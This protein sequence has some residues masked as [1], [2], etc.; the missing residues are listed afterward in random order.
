MMADAALPRPY[1]LRLWY[2]LG[3]LLG[4][5]RVRL[6]AHSL[7]GGGENDLGRLPDIG[8]LVRFIEP[9][10]SA[11]PEQLPEP[12]SVAELAPG[13]DQFG[14][15]RFLAMLGEWEESGG[16]HESARREVAKIDESLGVRV[17]FVDQRLGSIESPEP[18][19]QGRGAT[20]LV[21]AA[22]A[23][24]SDPGAPRPS[25][26]ASGESGADPAPREVHGGGPPGTTSDEQPDAGEAAAS[27]PAPGYLG[28]IVDEG[29]HQLR[30][31]GRAEV[32]ELGR[33]PLNLNLV[34]YF[35]KRRD[36]LT[37]LPLL[38]KVWEVSG[39]AAQP[40]E[41]TVR[42][43]ICDLN[44]LLRTLDVEINSS[45]GLWALKEVDPKEG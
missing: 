35:V 11:Y 28:L 8:P 40:E 23:V 38:L 21:D 17:H 18:V 7:S 4:D 19:G 25:P 37:D 9:L 26:A 29:R 32:V 43:R 22:L 30:R 10:P 5:Y 36:L 39:R 14:Q 42:D 45:F 1:P 6:V 31:A 3:V 20:P 24:A 13:L 15:S 41:S 33:G 12:R 2:Q 27:L 16:G 34:K 44:K